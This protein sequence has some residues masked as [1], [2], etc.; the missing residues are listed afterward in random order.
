M[1]A[2]YDLIALCEFSIGI[3]SSGKVAVENKNRVSP[4]L[5]SKSYYHPIGFPN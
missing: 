1:N 2:N 3:K 4:Y 5:I